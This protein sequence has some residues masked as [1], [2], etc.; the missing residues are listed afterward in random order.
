MNTFTA[1][2]A[3]QQPCRYFQSARGCWRGDSCSFRHEK[4][5]NSVSMIDKGDGIAPD[6]IVNQTQQL[7]IRPTSQYAPGKA[8]FC[9]FYNGSMGCRN[10]SSCPFTHSAIECS[11]VE[12][13]ESGAGPK[14][15]NVNVSEPP[16]PSAPFESYYMNNGVSPQRNMVYNPPNAQHMSLFKKI[17]SNSMGD[18]WE[19]SDL[20]PG[21]GR[22]AS[23]PDNARRLKIEEN[24]ALQR[25]KNEFISEIIPVSTRDLQEPFFAIDVECVATGVGHSDRDV[26]R[27]AVVSEDETVFYD[28]YV[29]PEKPIVSY[30][31]QLTGISPD[32]LVGAP[33]LKSIL[34]QL[35]T[36]LPKN[37]VIVGQSIKKDLE[38]LGLDKE[39]DYKQSFDVADLFRIPMQSQNGTIRYRNFSLRHV[40]K[41]L[42][43]TS[44][45][46][47]DHDPVIDAM[48]AM[49]VFKQFRY[50]HESPA[51]RD[52]VY[53]TLLQTPRTP[54]FAQRFPVVDGVAMKP[55][56]KQKSTS[57][58]QHSNRDK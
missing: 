2:N 52:A 27:I 8:N 47:A 28:Q 11:T 14:F 23:S 24:P 38:W 51:R 4:H 25:A 46:E 29:L 17:P 43:G 16:P 13:S 31:T 57:P 49:K 12:P 45:Q 9:R 32:D 41:Y 37:C 26:A 50:L 6:S 55:P 10:G 58:Y 15:A 19:D 44:I 48:Y 18:N 3:N 42:L 40:A 35:R 54:S 5:P 34:I 1:S 53:Q 56:R 30:L 20:G 33:S 36:I 7:S 21:T 22:P 39:K